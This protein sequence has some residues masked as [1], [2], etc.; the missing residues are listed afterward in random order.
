MSAH[1]DG[2]A[3]PLRPNPARRGLSDRLGQIRYRAALAYYWL[4]RAAGGPAYLDEV[5]YWEGILSQRPSSLFDRR[6][7]EAAFPPELRSCAAELQRDNRRLPRLLE[8]GSGPVSILAFG[9]DE[10][11]FTVVAVDPLALPYRYLLRFY[12]VTYPI[13]PLPGQ[14]EALLKQFSPASFDIAYSSNALDHTR[15]PRRCLE[16]MCEVVRP[17]GFLLL[18]G[19]VREG[20]HGNWSGLHQHDLLTE[21]GSL[22]HIDRAGRHTNLTADLPLTCVSE[23]VCQFKDRRIEAFG[24]EVSED[25]PPD[26]PWN[27]QD[28]YTLL[29]RRL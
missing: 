3:P 29:L 14:G 22:T 27:Y 9:I 16:Q 23:R 17:G 5:T 4:L 12:G 25:M 21:H 26:P 15:S 1:A 11:L 19:F 6:V 7:R 8:L 20:T 13:Q 2:A 10:G 28:W 24:Y 18:E